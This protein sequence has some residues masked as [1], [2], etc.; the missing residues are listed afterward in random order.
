MWGDV[1]HKGLVVADLFLINLISV[2]VQLFFL[3]VLSHEF[4][5][6]KLAC[7]VFLN[8]YFNTFLA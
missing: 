7:Y 1:P 6:Q 8:L 5:F 4:A 2:Y 3:L